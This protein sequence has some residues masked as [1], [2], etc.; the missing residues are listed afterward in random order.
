[1]L[2]RQLS[3]LNASS[4]VSEAGSGEPAG[5][6]SYLRQRAKEL[7]ADNRQLRR[8]MVQVK[9]SKGSEDAAKPGEIAP[10]EGGARQ[11][12]VAQA[13]DQSVGMSA[14]GNQAAATAAPTSDEARMLL[15]RL[16]QE[17]ARLRDENEKLMEMS[18]ALRYACAACFSSAT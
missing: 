1:M 12:D 11:Q 9:L 8:Q 2:Q 5:E 17:V 7:A 13:G 4:S 16:E 15:Q 14:Q 10:V 3:G 18:N 6:L